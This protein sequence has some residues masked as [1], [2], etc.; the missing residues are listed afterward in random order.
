MATVSLLWSVTG[1]A[2]IRAAEGG[3]VRPCADHLLTSDPVEVHADSAA[4]GRDCQPPLLVGQLL[5]PSYTWD[6]MGAHLA[7]LRGP[8]LLNDSDTAAGL[9][10]DLALAPTAVAL[11]QRAH[12]E[13][14]AGHALYY[15]GLL[16]VLVGAVGV[17]V[18]AAQTTDSKA[19]AGLGVSGGVLLLAGAVCTVLGAV[20]INEGLGHVLDAVNA[21]NL[22]LVRGR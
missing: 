8:G 2:Q 14:L 12:R 19:Q 21:Y 6:L 7:I 22:E 13:L 18:G 10:L 9:A 15:G 20:N 16:A 3:P 1:A 17:T 4:T 5:L 11:A